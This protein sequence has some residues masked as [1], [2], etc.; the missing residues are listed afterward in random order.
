MSF[1]IANNLWVF[2]VGLARMLYK[3]YTI[4]ANQVGTVCAADTQ[5]KTCS[6]TISI[7][8]SYQPITFVVMGPYLL[9]GNFKCHC[10]KNSFFIVENLNINHIDIYSMKDRIE[11][12]I[13]MGKSKVLNSFL[14]LFHT[15]CSWYETETLNFFNNILGFTE[16]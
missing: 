11:T 16:A 12:K 7:M 9:H 14:F 4:S 3:M 2:C 13:F 5:N 1:K 8:M 10:R 6:S 15:R